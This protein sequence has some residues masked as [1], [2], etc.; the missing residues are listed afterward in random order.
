MS[1]VIQITW[2]LNPALML[3]TCEWQRQHSSNIPRAFLHFQIPLQLGWEL[4][5]GS[6]QGT[7]DGRGGCHFQ[8]VVVN[9]S[10]YPSSLPLPFCMEAIVPAGIASEGTKCTEP[11]S[12]FV[13]ER[14]KSSHC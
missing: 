12:D 5:L 9:K 11:S 14:N 3:N 8:A 2:V 13:K 6:G 10:G 7:L 4:V 1:F